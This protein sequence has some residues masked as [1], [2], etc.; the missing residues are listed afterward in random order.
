MCKLNTGADL[1]LFRAR[2][3]CS[4]RRLAQLL[5]IRTQELV[6]ME[7]SSCALP[8]VVNLRFNDL[9]DFMKYDEIPDDDVS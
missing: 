1:I 4:R 3:N 2:Y 5:R 7:E 6:R 9:K 8:D